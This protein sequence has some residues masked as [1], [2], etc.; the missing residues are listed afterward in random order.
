MGNGPGLA[1]ELSSETFFEVDVPAGVDTFRIATAGGT[2][3]VDLFVAEGAVA[4]CQSGEEL[5]VP[6][7]ADHASI[8]DD[9]NEEID[10]PDPTAGRWFIDLN[11]FS[12]YAGVTLTT[13]V[14]GDT[15]LPSIPEG[16]V[17]LATQTPVIPEIS[18]GAIVT[19]A[20]VNFAPPGTFVISPM[21]DGESRVTTELAKTC[22]EIGGFLS[23]MFAA[24]S[25]QAN[26][27]AH[28]QLSL[29]LQDVFLIRDCGTVDETRSPA[30]QVNVNEVSPGFFHFVNNL[31]GV[32]PI[33]ALHGGGPGLVGEPRL[34]PKADFTEAEPD[35]VVSFFA[36]GFGAYEN[37][38][39]GWAD[40]RYCAGWHKR[41]DAYG[42]RRHFGD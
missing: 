1:G 8:G 42:Q 37:P 5:A 31:D 35:E 28:H 10:I 30:G 22:L 24:T 21:L 33:A 38:A 12:E 23:P 2:G 17:A 15:L 25:G 9:N 6:C 19:A 13:E 3:D 20:G 11:A 40:P 16:G 32:N 7:V 4:V 41:D 27:Q 34:L 18:P 26:A 36:T 39:G 14:T 29:G